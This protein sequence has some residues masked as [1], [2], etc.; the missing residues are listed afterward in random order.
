MKSFMIIVIL[1]LVLSCESDTSNDSNSSNFTHT[2]YEVLFENDPNGIT[3]F[4]TGVNY[5]GSDFDKEIGRYRFDAI[6]VINKIFETP[7]FSEYKENYNAIILYLDPEPDQ[8]SFETSPEQMV[9]SLFP[10]FKETDIILISTKNAS[11]NQGTAGAVDAAFPNNNM[12]IMIHEVGHVAGK[13]GE[14]YRVPCNF[15]EDTSTTANLDI[16]NDEQLVKWKHFIN[17]PGYNEIGVFKRSCGTPYAAWKPSRNCI[18]DEGAKFCAVCRE[19][20]VKNIM[21]ATN[22]P[23]DFEDFLEMD[24]KNTNR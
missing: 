20:I 8:D 18:M 3:L 15:L 12:W 10:N 7:P 24:L 2:D 17:L 13:L 21:I 4:F 14:E 1:L 6:R 16:T 5:K 22:R 23:Y 11:R 9:R 19:A